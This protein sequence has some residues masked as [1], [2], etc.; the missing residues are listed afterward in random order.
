M[1]SGDY[2]YN[3]SEVGEQVERVEHPYDIRDQM[4]TGVG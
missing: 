4:V 2:P 3:V 1:M